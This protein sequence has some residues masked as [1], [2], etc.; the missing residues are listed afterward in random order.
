M[1][2][3]KLARHFLAE[4][5]PE[6]HPVREAIDELR[7][8]RA[9]EKDADK[10]RM[11]LGVVIAGPTLYTDDGECSDASRFPIIDFLRDTPEQ[12]AAALRLRGLAKEVK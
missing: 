2:E 5:L 4:A 6:G 10:L 11:L 3:D 7:R 9:V 1:I 12:I 8:L